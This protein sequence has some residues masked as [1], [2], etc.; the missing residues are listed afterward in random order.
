MVEAAAAVTVMARALELPPVMAGALEPPPAMTV[1]AAVRAAAPSAV[2]AVAPAAPP[3]PAAG[4]T[5]SSPPEEHREPESQGHS[6]RRHVPWT[7]AA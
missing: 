1:E 7:H 2:E 4:L 5:D 3:S 6:T